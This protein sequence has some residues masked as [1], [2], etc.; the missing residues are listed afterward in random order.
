MNVCCLGDKISDTVTSRV[1]Q[2][3]VKLFPASLTQPA[4]A[5]DCSKFDDVRGL[6]TS[7]INGLLY[8]YNQLKILKL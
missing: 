1:S 2:Q 8:S 4:D 5:G 3:V 7:G 6:A